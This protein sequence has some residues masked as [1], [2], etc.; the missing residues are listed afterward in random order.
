MPHPTPVSRP[1]LRSCEPQPLTMPASPALDE[2]LASNKAYLASGQHRPDMKLGVS[3]RIV[4][5]TCM[6]SR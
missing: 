4:V 6:D 2:V 5:L 3:R 1:T